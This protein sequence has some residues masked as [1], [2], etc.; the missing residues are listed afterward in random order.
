MKEPASACPVT[1]VAKL[2]SDAWTMRIMHELLADPKRF[3]ELERDLEGISTRTL[4]NKLRR[5]GEEGLTEKD[6]QGNYR[7]T[8]KGAGLKPTIAAMRA[9]GTKFL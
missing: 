4:T 8:E 5:L 1:Q 7:A 9:Y 3:C 6:T 2:L